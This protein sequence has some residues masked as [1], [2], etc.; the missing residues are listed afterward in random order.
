MYW[1]LFPWMESYKP[2][3]GLRKIAVTAS[4]TEGG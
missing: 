1:N 4:H 2:Q 3:A